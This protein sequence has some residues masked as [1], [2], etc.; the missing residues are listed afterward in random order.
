[1]IRSKFIR[2]ASLLAAAPLLGV[3][4]QPDDP[5]FSPSVIQS[6]IDAIW[7]TL[8]DIGAQPFRTSDRAAVEALYNQ[9]R[10]SVTSPMTVREAWVAISPLLGALND[11]HVG[12]GFPTALNKAPLRF[13]LFFSLG[14]DRSLILHKDR[15]K[16]IPIGSTIVSIDGVPAAR[17]TQLTLAAFGGQTQLLWQTRVTAAGAWTAVALFGDRPSYKVRWIDPAGGATHEA[18]VTSTASPSPTASK[19]APYTYA[20]LRNGTVGYIDYLSCEDL[21]RF[22]TFLDSTFT[23]IEAAP[24]KALI[25]D[26]RRNAGGSS[27]LNDLLWTYVTTKPFK[28]FGGVIAKSCDRLKREYGQDLYVKMYGDRAW[29]APNGTIVTSGA[30]P[31]ADLIVPGPLPI[32][33][34]GPVYLLISAGTF[35]SA[36]SCALAAKDYGLAT[37]VGQETGEP[38]NSTGE[39][40]TETTPGLGLQAWLTTSVFLSPKPHPDRQGVMPDVPV[41]V[42][43]ADLAAG[44]D[45]VLERTLD[46][47]SQTDGIER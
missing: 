29:R 13:P 12:L 3:D 2:M 4:S 19:P 10:A 17:F 1:M 28:Q 38:V 43:T 16:T 40:Y 41:P 23:Q 22:R 46:L 39:V 6:D 8:I 37:I 44:R 42:T 27:N 30:D 33:F 25:I 21:P 15:T 26:I 18:D 32:R 9:I 20:T 14:D 31:G 35:S 11:G 36:M 34:S 24:I 5:T 45:V 7:K 47:I